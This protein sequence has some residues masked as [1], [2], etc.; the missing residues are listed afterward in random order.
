MGREIRMVPPNWSHPKNDRGHEQPMF[1]R[2]FDDAFA[3]WLAD[4]DR[5]RAG[6]L[7]QFEECYAEDGNNPLAAWLQ[8]YS[9]PDPVYYRPW[10]D[11]EATWVQVWETVTEGTPVSPPFATR[12]EV[13]EYLVAGGDD[14][15]R[16]RG[17]GGYTRSQ[18][19]AFVNAGWAPSF[20]VS[21]GQVAAGIEIPALLEG[22]K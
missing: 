5:I 20:V 14:W 4:F 10:R 21:A 9:P 16:R 7:D 6:K 18:A 13:V 3:D 22:S 12:E 1:D 8:D 2:N 19:E 17:R 11:E 15:D